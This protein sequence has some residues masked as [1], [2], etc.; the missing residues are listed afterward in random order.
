MSN[1]VTYDSSDFHPRVFVSYSS[2][3]QHNDW[4]LR[5]STRLISNGVN[6]VL[7]QW[8]VSLGSDLAHFMEHGLTGA[9][10][11][12]A[13]CSDAYIAKANAG[14]RGVG[15][16]KKIMTGDLITQAVNDHIVPVIRDA[17][18]AKVLPTFLTGSRYVDFRDDLEWD[19]K[20]EELLYDLYGQ[21]IKSKPPLGANP[22][23]ANGTTLTTQKV[24]F[25]PTK[26][27]ST[28]LRGTVTYPYENNNGQFA[29]GNGVEAFT[30]QVT[31]AGHG[32][33]HVYNDPSNI[34]TIALAVSTGIDDVLAPEE[35][36]SSSR[37]RTARVGDS[38]VIINTA[39][40]VAAFEI[41]D[42]TTRET[43]ADGIPQISLRYAIAK[44]N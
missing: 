14:S 37:S 17:S 19:A 10:R 6:V 7:D 42:V 23:A 34:A 15:Y 38:I 24:R 13:I 16:E 20:Y 28:A 30:I 39:G 5:L 25:D 2:A 44:Q 35:Y 1:D 36:D 4:V 29:I 3:D 12:I 31:T 9:D 33:V 22:F 8:D 27:T 26:Y 18:G 43:A 41:L 40:R 32:S 21:R 11:V